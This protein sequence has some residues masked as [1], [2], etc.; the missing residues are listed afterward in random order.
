MQQYEKHSSGINV[1]VVGNS[2]DARLLQREKVLRG[3][4]LTDSGITI[5]L[6]PKQPSNAEYPI[7]SRLFGR[8][9]VKITLPENA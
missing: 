4:F 9:I 3:R 5:A 8:D 6:N 7:T 1:I 2:T